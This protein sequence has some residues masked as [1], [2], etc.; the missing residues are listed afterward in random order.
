MAARKRVE[1]ELL[2]KER[3]ISEK[4]TT[5]K[6]L[7][8]KN[9]EMQQKINALEAIAAIK[10]D[11]VQKMNLAQELIEKI[12]EAKEKLQKELETAS[13]YLLE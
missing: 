11:L 7:T 10:E 1:D 3:I 5:I 13:D 9:L 6:E 8:A 4:D 2:V 12:T